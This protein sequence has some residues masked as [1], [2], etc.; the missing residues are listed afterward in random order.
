M[1]RIKDIASKIVE[2]PT[3]P[4]FRAGDTVTVTIKIREGN[5]E[6]LQKFKA[7]SSSAKARPTPRPSRYAKWHLV[8]VW[9]VYSLLLPRSL[10]T[11]K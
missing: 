2:T 10:K 7:L 4:D 3:W 5:K 11:S 8:S 6:R 1:D 9:N